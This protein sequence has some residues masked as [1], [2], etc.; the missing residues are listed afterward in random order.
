MT[1]TGQLFLSEL[2]SAWI[3]C[4]IQV[5]G[6]TGL[7]RMPE[8]EEKVELRDSGVGKERSERGREEGSCKKF[9]EEECESFPWPPQILESGLSAQGVWYM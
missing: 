4:W 9:Y 5:H 6:R 8:G 3:S 1:S 7:L 2:W